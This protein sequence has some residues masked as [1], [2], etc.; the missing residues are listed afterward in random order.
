[1]PDKLQVELNKNYIRYFDGKKEIKIK[2]IHLGTSLGKEAKEHFYGVVF[3]FY[4]DNYKAEKVKEHPLFIATDYQEGILFTARNLVPDLLVLES[5]KETA[6]KHL[7][8]SIGKIF[9]YKKPEIPLISDQSIIIEGIETSL[10]PNCYQVSPIGFGLTQTYQNSEL[11]TA[12][13]PFNETLSPLGKFLADNHHGL[14]VK[15]L[16]KTQKKDDYRKVQVAIKED[17]LFS[18]IMLLDLNTIGKANLGIHCF[19]V[20]PSYLHLIYFKKLLTNLL[21]MQISYKVENGLI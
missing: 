11:F 19:V 4:F 20:H 12:L 5:L 17:P 18:K 7:K 10:N 1:M 13:I 8:Q 3:A 21:K 6:E 16:V 14:R 9:I 15:Y 2:P